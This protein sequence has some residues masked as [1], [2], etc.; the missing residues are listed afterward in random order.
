M[1]AVFPVER[2]L[3]PRTLAIVGVS[4]DPASM[5]GRAL[6][7]VDRFGFTGDVHLVS[8]GNVKVGARDCVA[9]IDDL[10]DNIDAMVLA[11]PAAGVLQAVEA[12]ARRGVG[13]I[14]LFA[15]GFSEAGPDG[16]AEQDRIAKI[17]RAAGIALLG[18]NTLGITNYVDGISLGFG[19]NHPSPPGK[20]PAMAVIAQSGAMAACMRLSA[21][22][23]GLAVSHS[24]ATGNEAVTGVEDYLAAFV[25]D[26]AARAIAVFAEQLRRPRLFLELARRARQNGKPVILLNPGRSRRAR[27][28]AASHTGALSGDHETMRAMVAGEAVIAVDTLEEF[29]DASE[30]F[31]RFPKPSVRGPAVITDSGAFKGLALDFAETIGLDLPE[32]SEIT[33]AKLAARLPGFAAPT[34]PLDITAQGLK[35]MPLYAEAAKILLEDEACG[36][37]LLAVMPGSPDVGQIKMRTVLPALGDG[38]KPTAYVILGGAAPIAPDVERAV[39]D[40]GLPFHRSPE[41]AL[42]AFGH[43]Q[44]YA[45][46]RD[47]AAAGRASHAAAAKRIAGAGIVPEYESKRLLAGLGLR[48]PEGVLA[49]TVDAAVNAANQI[50]WPVVLKAQSA[51]LPHKTE[52]GGVLIDLR[53]EAALRAGWDA[54]TAGVVK[55]KPGLALD[56]MLVEA[57]GAPGLEMV[58]G[59][60]NDADW[61]PL[62]VFGLGGVWTEALADVRLLRADATTAHIIDEL[63]QLRGAALLIGSRG[64][65]AVDLEALAVAIGSIGELLCRHPEIAEIDVNPLIAYPPGAKP[66]ALDALIVLKEPKAAN[67]SR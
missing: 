63:K 4:E 56:G 66:L 3:R 50:G 36:G 49:G 37:L 31:T 5:G 44:R 24:V 61:G 32:I 41:R 16:R 21:G 27:D 53:S 65:P 45:K 17:A 26:P 19:P 64:A 46:M 48:V 2:L 23:R 28:S 52:A 25:D 20:R 42:R 18:P 14:V 58:A 11:L 10:P 15:A 43:W 62:L 7:N 57:M 12:A 1:D 30:F 34:N 8:R 29:L 35:D 51:R 60:R 39:L 67:D 59:G 47:R 6:A 54:I 33:R 13:A 9:S 55:A 22:E 38:G 40:A